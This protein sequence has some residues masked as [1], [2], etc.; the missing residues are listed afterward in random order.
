LENICLPGGGEHEHARCITYSSH[1][2]TAN[3]THLVT[4][5]TVCAAKETLLLV[6]HP[7]FVPPPPPPPAGGKMT[8]LQLSY[9]RPDMTLT[10]S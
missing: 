8:L 9:I 7:S 1:R 4:A 6:R 5:V 10:I 2:C 3:N